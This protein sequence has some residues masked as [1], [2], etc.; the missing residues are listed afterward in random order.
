MCP[1]PTVSIGPTAIEPGTPA[2][3]FV[4]PERLRLCRQDDE[5]PNKLPG[6]VVGEIYLGDASLYRACV[7]PTALKSR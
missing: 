7:L 2:L 4:R 3:I 6:R 5:L 1:A